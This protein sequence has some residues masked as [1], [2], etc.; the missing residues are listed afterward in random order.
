MKDR[1]PEY[2]KRG[3]PDLIHITLLSL[4]ESPLNKKGLLRLYVHTV[5]D[6]VIFIDPRIRLPKNYN[7]FVGLMEQLFKEGRV[8]PRESEK[9]LMILRNLSLRDLVR[10]ISNNKPIILSEKGE[11]TR[12]R[13]LA[14]YLVSNNNPVIIGGFQHGDF[15]DKT[16]KLTDKVYSIYEEPLPTWIVASHLVTLYEDV[17]GII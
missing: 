16:Y 4:L 12:L 3:R 11:K 6:I 1:L 13:D 8:P 10:K 9:P 15:S 2:Y 14:S 17:M 7:R 5:N